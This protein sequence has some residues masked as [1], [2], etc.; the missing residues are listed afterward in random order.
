MRCP[1]IVE[2]LRTT[3]SVRGP[4]KR[5]CRYFTRA[6]QLLMQTVV[7]A[8]ISPPHRRLLSSGRCGPASAGHRQ[9]PKT[10]VDR[11]LGATPH[12]EHGGVERAR[13]QCVALEVRLVWCNCG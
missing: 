1:A 8:L 3:T 7:S 6:P 10:L 12:A 11:R 13:R 5:E 2:V 4:D 9:V